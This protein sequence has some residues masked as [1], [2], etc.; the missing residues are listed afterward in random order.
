MVIDS[1]TPAHAP[2][3]RALVSGTVRLVSL[4]EIYIRINEILDD[5]SSSAADIGEVIGRDASLTARLLRIVNSAFYGFPSRVETVS[6]AVAII[7]SRE[8]RGLVLAASAIEA[9]T[10]LPNDVL[11]LA[12]FWRHSVYCGVVAQ[13]LAER[14]RVLHSE[15]L[16]VAGLLHDIGK[17]ILC[18]RLPE[19]CR[20]IRRRAR[21]Q[22][23]SD[24]EL[25]REVLGFDHAQVGGE[26][27]QAWQMPAALREA[28]TGHHEPQRAAGDG[29][30]PWLVHLANAV[31]AQAEE[32]IEGGGAPAPV[33]PLA[34]R[35]TG[36]DPAVSTQIHRDAGPRFTDALAIIMPRHRPW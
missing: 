9:L 20:A 35:L 34:W 15:R 24:V 19:E 14:C 7:G 1:L 29:L 28:V 25:E 21:E 6:R 3:A 27:L 4:P 30:D 32:A 18:H 16:F 11:K 22:G 36:L 23:C 12:D 13:L 8:L 5:P 31:T 2:S 26:L 33:D 17:L 10:Q